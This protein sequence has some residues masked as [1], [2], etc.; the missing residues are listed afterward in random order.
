MSNNRN[1]LKQFFILVDKPLF[2]FLIERII[3]MIFLSILIIKF[4]TQILEF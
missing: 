4:K 3:E 1:Y 2:L